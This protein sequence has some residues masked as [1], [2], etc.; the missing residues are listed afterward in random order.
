MKTS[1]F[2]YIMQAYQNIH[3]CLVILEPIEY[4]MCLALFLKLNLQQRAISQLLGYADSAIFLRT[5][6]AKRASDQD[7][8]TSCQHVGV[9]CL[10]AL[11]YQLFPMDY[12][13]GFF[14]I[15]FGTLF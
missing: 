8:T 13:P 15:S 7:K 6:E 4:A 11:K 1:W 9:V 10:A 12:V 5:K 3:Y 14:N 2:V